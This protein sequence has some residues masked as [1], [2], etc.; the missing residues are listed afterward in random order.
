MEAGSFRLIEA[1]AEAIGRRVL[2]SHPE[3]VSVR[4]LVRKPW[5][6]LGG[7]SDGT[8]ALFEEDRD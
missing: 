7:L 1:M 4:V 6:P 3:V 5:A 2:A 8:E